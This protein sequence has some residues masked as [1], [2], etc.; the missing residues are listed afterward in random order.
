MFRRKQVTEKKKGQSLV[1]IALMMVAILGMIALAIDGGTLWGQRR[2]MQNGADSA[3]LGGATLLGNSV[4]AYPAGEAPN[5]AIP[6]YFVA[7]DAAVR[8]VVNSI[9][10][11]EPEPGVSATR[12]LTSTYQLSYFV[13]TDGSYNGILTDLTHNQWV[14]SPTGGQVP[15]GT[16]LVRVTP[17]TTLEN[18]IAG[19]FGQGTTDVTAVAVAGIYGEDLPSSPPGELIP[20]TAWTTGS[21]CP[22]HH[23]ILGSFRTKPSPYGGRSRNGIRMATA[24]ITI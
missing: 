18:F 6:I 5:P 8:E 9:R 24:R 1:L 15:D 20:L 3:A 22:T 7:S 14:S 21:R 17:R 4:A 13:T 11:S 10:P 2:F 19:I 23:S 16:Y 12:T